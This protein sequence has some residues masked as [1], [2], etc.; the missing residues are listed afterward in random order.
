MKPNHLT[1]AQF[2]SKKNN[3]IAKLSLQINQ[4]LITLDQVK[5]CLDSHIA[6]HLRHALIKNDRL[7]LYADSAL[8]ASQLRFR[9]SAIQSVIEKANGLLLKSVKIKV[10]TLPDYDTNHSTRQI[11]LPSQPVINKIRDQGL[12]MTDPAL[13]NALT[14]LSDTLD[15]LRS[16][17]PCSSQRNG[18]PHR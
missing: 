9:A 13:R 3:A 10:M 6:A 11:V 7:L 4:Q 2:L 17:S 15:R 14:G 5:N 12:S 16:G 18:L 8:W 1:V